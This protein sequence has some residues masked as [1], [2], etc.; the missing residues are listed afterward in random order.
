MPETPRLVFSVIGTEENDLQE[1]LHRASDV[2]VDFVE[3]RSVSGEAVTW[4]TIVTL[5]MPALPIVWDVIKYLMDRNKIK[6]IEVDGVKIEN[7]T[8]DVVSEYLRKD[9]S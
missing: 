4:V 2:E 9:A 1:M 6:S 7:P 3:S 5:T 8:K